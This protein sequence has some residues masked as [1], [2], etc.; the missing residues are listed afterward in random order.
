ME[1]IL[2]KWAPQL[3]LRIPKLTRLF[4]SY[5]Q[6]KLRQPN[7]VNHSNWTESCYK[8]LFVKILVHI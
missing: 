7:L 6:K 3:L 5:L 1:P 2:N 8:N 4:Q